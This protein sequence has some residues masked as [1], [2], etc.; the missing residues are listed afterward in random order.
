MRAIAN[1]NDQA[2]AIVKE[3]DER[4]ALYKARKKHQRTVEYGAARKS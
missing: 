2:A 3:I 4:R 1:S